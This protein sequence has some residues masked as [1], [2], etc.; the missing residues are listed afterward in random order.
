[1]SKFIRCELIRISSDHNSQAEALA[2]LASTSDMKLPRTITIFHLPISSLS[3]DQ[4]IGV[5]IPDPIVHWVDKRDG[6]R[7]EGLYTIDLGKDRSRE[8]ESISKAIKGKEILMHSLKNKSRHQK[9]G[10]GAG[11]IILE[12]RKV[13]EKVSE[14]SE[15]DNLS[16]SDQE[17]TT[18]IVDVEGNNLSWSLDEEISKVIETG[19]ALGFD[20]GNNVREIRNELAR[21][22]EEDAARILQ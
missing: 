17:E 12:K 20:F 2:K 1:M 14:S 9:Q 15:Y 11:S 22:E 7:E 13:G 3:E 4:E 16:S 19:I 21:R 18:P 10:V 5:L 8:K 6:R